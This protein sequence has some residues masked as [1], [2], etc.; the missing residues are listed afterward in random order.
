MI[1]VNTEHC[2]KLKNIAFEQY[3]WYSVGNFLLISEVSAQTVEPLR[4]ASHFCDPCF[5]C[6]LQCSWVVFVHIRLYSIKLDLYSQ[7]SLWII[8]PV[9]DWVI[10]YR[11]PEFQPKRLNRKCNN[12]QFKLNLYVQ[13]LQFI[14][15]VSLDYSW[16]SWLIIVLV[17]IGQVRL[18]GYYWMKP[19]IS[20]FNTII[21]SSSN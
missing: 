1:A 19:D 8:F 20:V 12:I 2:S 21:S 18:A 15:N 6:L 3:V 13:L 4:I 17:F 9:I 10:M 14:N 5:C 16:V 11:Y 7:I